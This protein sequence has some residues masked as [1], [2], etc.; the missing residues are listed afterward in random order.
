MNESDLLHYKNLLLAKQQELPAS[1]SLVAIGFFLD[2]VENHRFYKRELVQWLVDYC[3][4]PPDS[5]DEAVIAFLKS[6]TP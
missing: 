3:G 4:L 5:D 2:A 1:E 6:R